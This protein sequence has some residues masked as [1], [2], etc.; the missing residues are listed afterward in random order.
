MQYYYNHL[1]IKSVIITGKDSIDYLQRIST[2]NCSRLREVKFLTTCFLNDKGK[3]VDIC[4][5]FYVNSKIYLISCSTKFGET[6]KLL[7][8]Y[9]ITDDVEISKNNDSFD[10]VEFINCDENI[11]SEFSSPYGMDVK[12]GRW[13]VLF[14]NSVSNINSILSEIK[15]EEFTYLNITSG[16]IAVNENIYLQYNPLELNLWEYISFTKGCY[17]GQEIIA[18]LDSYQKVSKTLVLLSSNKEEFNT[19]GR[20]LQI[21]NGE[22]AGKVISEFRK[23]ST[24]YYL[25]V[26]TSK[27]EECLKFK[28]E[29][30]E[31]ELVKEK[32]FRHI[33]R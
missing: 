13:K 17:L 14:I 22:F 19:V 21:E 28:L 2:N 8:K 4:D 6:I 27:M 1:N 20:Q 24:I 12:S 23:D 16:L 5:L 25:A 9:I 26:V 32:T 30:T 3:L 18:R 33:A 10:F 31:Y 11:I 29:T 15:T 7:Q